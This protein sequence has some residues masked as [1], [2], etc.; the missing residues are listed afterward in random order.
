MQ[1]TWI[2]VMDKIY[3]G[4]PISPKAVIFAKISPPGLKIPQFQN[5][6]QVT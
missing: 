1:S 5:I 3:A 6:R 2:G 4:Q